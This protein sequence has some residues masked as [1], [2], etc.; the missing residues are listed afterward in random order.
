MG[1]W[2]PG[3]EQPQPN[4][5]GLVAVAVEEGEAAASLMTHAYA[6]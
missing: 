5:T 2:T 6:S 1:E 4:E 3:Q